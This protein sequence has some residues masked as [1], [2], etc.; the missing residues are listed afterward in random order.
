MSKIRSIGQKEYISTFNVASTTPQ[1]GPRIVQEARK[2]RGSQQNQEAT[3]K[4][5]N[6]GSL[7]SPSIR[8]SRIAKFHNAQGR[9]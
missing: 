4:L 6:R 9:E 1:I 2:R 8:D 7:A 3:S 5:A